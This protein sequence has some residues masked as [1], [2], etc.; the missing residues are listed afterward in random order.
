MLSYSVQKIVI[1][2][3]LLSCLMCFSAVINADD[4]RDSV[5]QMWSA[6]ETAIEA[7]EVDPL[8]QFYHDDIVVYVPG[9]PAAAGK[10]LNR[11]RNQERFDNFTFVST[12]TLD[13]IEVHGDTAF[14]S[15]NFWIEG[16][17]KQ[18]DGGFVATGRHIVLLK[19]EG[20]RGWQ[21]Y[22]DFYQALPEDA[23]LPV[24]D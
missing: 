15:G 2:S 14:L 21:V 17:A 20:S 24:V 10:V 8:M 4:D 6:F 5:V 19:R 7:G 23:R 22:R 13:E 18:G 16:K 11:K 1:R 9:K 3:L 12:Q